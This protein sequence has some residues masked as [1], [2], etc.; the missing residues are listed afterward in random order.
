MIVD[1][2]EQDF[3]KLIKALVESKIPSEEILNKYEEI[4]LKFNSAQIS[5]I[6]IRINGCKFQKHEEIIINSGDA[7]SCADIVDI[8][9]IDVEKIKAIVLK[10][11]NVDA[12]IACAII[13]YRKGLDISAFDR[14]IV[15]LK[16]PFASCEFC[17]KIQIANIPEHEA[18]VRNSKNAKLCADFIIKVKQGMSSEELLCTIME[19]GEY[20]YLIDVASN[21]K[22]LDIENIRRYILL[23]IIK[24]KNPLACYLYALNVKDSNRVLLLNIALVNPDPKYDSIKE[25]CKEELSYEIM[26]KE[27]L[28]NAISEYR[29]EL[30]EPKKV[31][32]HRNYF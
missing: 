25:R 19:S 4:A 11:S 7:K 14:A 28:N 17:E 3:L 15:Q 6:F 24:N 31:E 27:E 9:G 2:D 12:I 16:N 5:S 29:K 10:S 21:D 23:K 22:L 1:I 18:I 20:E 26:D 8:D 13:L 32:T 30:R